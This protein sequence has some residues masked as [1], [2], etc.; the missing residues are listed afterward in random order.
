MQNNGQ[1]DVQALAAEMMKNCPEAD[2]NRIAHLI[3]RYL[4][5]A[6]KDE[7]FYAALTDEIQVGADRS[8]HVRMK[9]GDMVW[10]FHRKDGN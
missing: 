4:S 10:H 9:G 8:I 1:I 7:A 5:G 6:E 3:R 2:D